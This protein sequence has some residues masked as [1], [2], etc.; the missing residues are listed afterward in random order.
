MVLGVGGGNWQLCGKQKVCDFFSQPYLRHKHAAQCHGRTEA[1]TEAHRDDFVV[2]TKVDWYKGQPDD[3]GGVHGKGNVL[4]LI[5]I[6][7]DVAGLYERENKKVQE[8][9]C[10]C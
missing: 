1:D 5:E 9:I 8:N 6:G 3:T 2:G 10:S 4:S 7:R